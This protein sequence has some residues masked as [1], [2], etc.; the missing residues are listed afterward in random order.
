MYVSI[1]SPKVSHLFSLTIN[2]D[3]LDVLYRDIN[4]KFKLGQE[5]TIKIV[6]T[7]LSANKLKIQIIDPDIVS[8]FGELAI[9]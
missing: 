1:Y 7:F 2:G 5:I 9:Y 4:L 8:I 6:I 3:E